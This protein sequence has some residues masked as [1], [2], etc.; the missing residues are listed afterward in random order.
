LKLFDSTK[1]PVLSRALEAYALRHKTIASNLANITTPGYSAKVVKFE[2]QL[3][4]AMQ[5]PEMSGTR[6]HKDHIPI[7][8]ANI[9]GVQPQIVEQSQANLPSEDQLASGANNVDIDNEMAELAKNQI[10]FRYCARLLSDTFRGIQ[11]SIRGTQ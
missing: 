11:K 7:G 5:Q 8:E 3:A 1:V 4:G 2:D 9:L 10:R 6:T